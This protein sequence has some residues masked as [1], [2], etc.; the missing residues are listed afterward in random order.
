MEG[1]G[2]SRRRNPWKIWKR[3]LSAVLALVLTAGLVLQAPLSFSD[4]GFHVSDAYASGSNANRADSVWATASNARYKEGKSQDVDIYVIAEDNEAAPGNMM[5]MDLYLRNNTDQVITEGILKFK[6]NH[7]EKENGFFY[8]VHIADGSAA[9]GMTETDAADAIGADKGTETG[10]IS[11]EDILYE[12][13]WAGQNVEIIQDTESAQNGEM[14]GT[15]EASVLADFIPADETT[16]MDTADETDEEEALYELTDLELLPGELYEVRFDFYTEDD[17]N[18]T[19]AYVE[20]TFRGENES[21]DTVKS[22]S[23][24]YYSIGL[25]FVSLSLEDGQKVESGISNDME[26]WMR[27]PSWVDEDLEEK[28]ARQEEKEAEKEYAEME[29]E[30]DTASSSNASKASDSNASRASDSNAD[31]QEQESV[32]DQEKIQQ[33][34]QEAMKIS[35]SR[36]SY[37]IEIFGAKFEYFSPRKADEAEDIGWISCVYQIAS[38]TEPGI[39]YGKV[40][41]NGRWNNEKFTSEQGFFFEVTGEWTGDY[42][43]E[44]Q[45][46]VVHAHAED[47]VLPR[48]VSLKVTELAEG[49][50]AYAKA[51][52]ALSGTDAQYDGMMALDIS[53]VNQEGEEVEPDGEVQVTI[54]MKSGAFPEDAALETVEVHHLKEVDEGTVEVEVV[55][56]GAD[57]TDG[58]VKSAEEFAAGLEGT[59]ALEEETQ[60]AVSDDAAAVAAFS[61]ESFSTFTI[62]WWN[63]RSAEI[64]LIDTNGV[65]VKGKA[66]TA[67]I[68]GNGETVENLANRMTVNGYTF[69]KAVIAADETAAVGDSAIQISQLRGNNDGLQYRQNENNSWQTL[70]SNAQKIYFIFS[71]TELTTA[72][73]VDSASEG[74]HMY[75][76]DYNAPAYDDDVGRYGDGQT[77]EGLSTNTVDEN[78]WPWLN[79]DAANNFS[80]MSFSEMFGNSESAYEVSEA[81]AVN[82][83]FLKENYDANGDFYFNS[84]EYFATLANDDDSDFTVYNQLGTPSGESGES[85]FFYQRGNFMPYNTLDLGNVLNHNLYDDTGE[86]LSETDPRYNENLYGFN[87]A[88]NYY[89]GMYVWADFYQPEGGMVEDNDGEGSSPMIFEFTGD[90]DM[91]VYIDGVLVLDLGG[92][93]DAQSGSINFRTGEVKWTDT[94]TNKDSV[95]RSSNI[96]TLFANANAEE[97]KNWSGNTFADGSYHRIQIFY[98]ERGAGASNLKMSFNLKTIPDGQLAVRKD[99]ENYYA[100]QLEDIEYTMEVTTGE[101]KVPYANKEYTFFEQ[102]G[103]GTTDEKGQFKL[104]YGQTA[105][106]P[107]IEVGIQVNVR[108]ISSSDTLDSA[109]IDENY[110]ISYSITDSSGQEIGGSSTDGTA[111]AEMPAYG[112]V[113]VV[114][115]NTAK[116]TR[117]LRLVK[118]FSGTK[119]NAAPDGFQA[120]YTLYEVGQDGEKIE[121]EIGS[122]RYSEMTESDDGTSASYVFWLETD[123]RYTI[124]ESFDTTGDNNGGT[125]ELPWRGIDVVTNDPASDTKDADGIVYLE[126]ADATL[127]NASEDNP[128]DEIKITNR[129]AA[130]VLTINKIDADTEDA[131]SGVEFS[132]YKKDAGGEYSLFMGQWTTDANGQITLKNLSSGDYRLTETKAAPG[133]QLPSG[134]WDFSVDSQGQITFTKTNDATYEEASETMT[135]TNQAGVELPETGGPG[136]GLTKEFGWML[137]IL[138]AMMAGVEIH[139]YGRRKRS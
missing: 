132:L 35:E 26:I 29:D 129:Y 42:T 33:Y 89:F 7:I 31:R 32:K 90:D 70:S 52:E 34:T 46:V 95:E 47:G 73:T 74:V 67:Q 78:G 92:I 58:T 130:M 75:M 122:I 93:H 100:P 37:E 6:G 53:F 44:S 82:H 51:E 94:P 124:E 11:G 54:E 62:T 98:M 114:V 57:K 110:N 3:R 81:N 69:E 27:E 125:D 21:G 88:N 68:S 131:L 50:A 139:L 113:N 86:K 134:S 45:N 5:S 116:F 87:E 80:A 8:D 36:V 56:D 126:N 127:D 60:A 18:S 4:L 24:F 128:V 91:W 20:F 40:R 136:L 66:I 79:A 117:P 133:Y 55:A 83:L 109:E 63:G 22:D 72:E 119:D 99:V 28:I 118:N 123:K 106:F 71:T 115:T 13:T 107:D 108:E 96:K 12:E 104:K 59:E 102:E 23:R 137:L 17:E 64:Y 9:G 105:I 30:A 84:A 41:A 101:D 65:G 48:N 112:S 14:D 103:G 10:T 121:P 43:A 19:K 2:T 61:V 39:Y 15:G 85:R 25:P 16:E 76:F 1:R 111:S 138:A 38:H 49:D 77:K 135:I 120:T 97:S